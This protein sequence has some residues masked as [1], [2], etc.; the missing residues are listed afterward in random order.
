[1]KTP[2]KGRQKCLPFSIGAV[3][4]DEAAFL[5]RSENKSIELVFSSQNDDTTCVAGGN[6]AA[7]AKL[8]QER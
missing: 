7:R 1:V 8:L 2:T 3:E 6:N 4:R 5:G